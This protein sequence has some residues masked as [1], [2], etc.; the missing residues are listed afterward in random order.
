MLRPFRSSVCLF[1]APHLRCGDQGF[2]Q[3]LLLN[4]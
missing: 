2:A 1:R 4:R 3:D